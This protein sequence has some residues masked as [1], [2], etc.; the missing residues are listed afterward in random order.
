MLVALEYGAK[1]TLKIVFFSFGRFQSFLLLKL[2]EFNC[3]K[4]DEEYK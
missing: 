1:Y 3:K 4:K 2:Y